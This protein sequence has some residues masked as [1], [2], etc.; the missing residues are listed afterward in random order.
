M[1]LWAIAFLSILAAG[2]ASQVFAD[3]RV[4][5]RLKWEMQIR[6]IAWRGF[7]DAIEIIKTD[8]TAT[9]DT[10]QEPWASNEGRFKDVRYGD[11]TYQLTSETENGGGETVLRF[12]LVDEERKININKA[13]K[14]ILSKWLQVTGG[15]EPGEAETMALFIVDFR[16]EN[17]VKEGSQNGPEECSF[18]PPPSRCKNKSYEALEELWWVP[19]ME[20][21]LFRKIQKG[22]TLYGTGALNINTAG[23]DSLRAL[24][25]SKSGA[26]EIAKRTAAGSWAFK[27]VSQIMGEIIS[28]GLSN[29]DKIALQ[30]AIQ[31]DGVGVRSNV[32]GAVVK[33]A[34]DE[35]HKGNLHFIVNRNGEIKS[36]RE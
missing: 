23:V 36:W 28:W 5:S 11:A 27:E 14:D 20:E 1:T 26:E 21:K 4:A 16:D 9:Y 12:G 10:L 31:A 3:V 34:F 35:R 8:A 13:S 2:V 24:G 15:L 30:S 17:E 33:V 19:E 6:N 29:E 7:Y 25:L 18:V 32:Y 22:W